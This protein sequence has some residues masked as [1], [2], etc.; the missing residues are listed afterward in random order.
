VRVAAE[1]RPDWIDV[2]ARATAELVPGDDFGLP[3]H[4]DGGGYHGPLA[5]RQGKPMRPDVA[6]AFDRMAAA[7]RRE[8]GIYLLITSGYRSDAEQALLFT[9]NLDPK[10]VAPP[11]ESLHRYGTEL[12]LGP[13]TAYAWLAANGERF[14]FIKRYSWEAW[15]YELSLAHKYLAAVRRDEYGNERS[16]CARFERARLY[17]PPAAGGSRASARVSL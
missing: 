8:A 16:L 7:A 9:A 2:E 11:G 5:Y 14:G 3:D 15:H 13:A 17:C 6:L 10:W 4:A 1:R 12:D